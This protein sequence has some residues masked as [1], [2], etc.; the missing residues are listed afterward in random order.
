MNDS[1]YPVSELHPFIYEM[2]RIEIWV[3]M[4]SSHLRMVL[5]FSRLMNESS[6][7]TFNIRPTRVGGLCTRDVSCLCKPWNKLST[8]NRVYGSRCKRGLVETISPHIHLQIHR[9]CFRHAPSSC[10]LHLLSDHFE[11][12][13]PFVH[14]KGIHHTSSFPAYG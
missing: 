9:K 12:Q 1:D 6:L 10:R 13:F 3:T 14:T 7:S 2:F 11:S 8:Y 4:E 5:P